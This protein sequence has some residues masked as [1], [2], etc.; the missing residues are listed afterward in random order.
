M[1]RGSCMKPKILFPFPR[2][3]VWHAKTNKSKDVAGSSGRNAALMC[4]LICWPCSFLLPPRSPW[5]EPKS[6]CSPV[7][8]FKACGCLWGS[9]RCW[10]AVHMPSP[11]ISEPEE[12]EGLLSSPNAGSL[13]HVGTRWVAPWEGQIMHSA[14]WAQTVL[15]CLLN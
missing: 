13:S 5:L 10:G 15:K 4:A 6:H 2:L 3:S 11:C 12:A 7:E 9:P 14:L 8:V 1:R